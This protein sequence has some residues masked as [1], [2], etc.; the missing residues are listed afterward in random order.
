MELDY[1]MLQ[2][3]EV[4]DLLFSSSSLISYSYMKKKENQSRNNTP[5]SPGNT[6]DLHHHSVVMS[7]VQ[8]I[9]NHFLSTFIWMQCK[10][11]TT[12]FRKWEMQQV[13]KMIY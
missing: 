7:K 9:E 11:F 1:K 3:Y 8:K 6:D 4:I 2:L 12:Y 13:E 10:H 5:T